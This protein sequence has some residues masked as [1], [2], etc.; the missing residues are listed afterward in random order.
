MASDGPAHAVPQLHP[1]V[2]TSAVHWS[3]GDRKDHGIAFRQRDYRRARLHAW[4]LLGQYEL[5]TAKVDPG[6]G[7]QHRH[8]QREDVLAVQVHGADSCS[9]PRR[10][11]AAA[12][13][14]ASDRQRCSVR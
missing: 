10:I 7:E 11:E 3:A 6:L 1:I 2:T 4:A 5:A 12:A 13:S 14:A 9:R 8:L